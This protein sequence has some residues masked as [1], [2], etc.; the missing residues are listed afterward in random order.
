MA[1]TLSKL[2]KNLSRIRD[3]I[4]AACV[5]TKRDPKDVKIVAVT[6]SVELDTIKRLLDVGLTEFGESQVQ[7]LTERSAELAAYLQRR[8]APLAQPVKWHMVGHLQRNKVRAAITA[9]DCLQSV[10]SLRLAEEIDTRAEA[11][12]QRIDVMLQVNCS[13]EA[14][15]FGC[16][17]GAAVHL[18]EIMCTLKN[19]RLVGLMTMAPQCED[20]NESRQAFT[21]LGELFEE[22]LHEKIG[23]DD[24]CH[25]SMGMS[26][27]YQVAVKEGA[28]VLRI[29]R[30]LFE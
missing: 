12:G 26:Q 13:E 10:D 4:A 6:K 24:F 8:Q 18:G 11:N 27:D 16:A 20:P 9:A 17:I 15:K 3:N 14:Q 28:N 25:L 19:L 5:G 1:I 29:G 22:M 23:G 7:Q 2:Q 21:R 30:A